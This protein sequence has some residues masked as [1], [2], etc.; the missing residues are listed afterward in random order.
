MK[1]ICK[2]LIIICL[3]TIVCSLSFKIAA[4]AETQSGEIV[5]GFTWEFDNNTLTISGEGALPE[6]LTEYP[7]NSYWKAYEEKIEYIIMDD[8]ITQFQRISNGLATGWGN[9]LDYLS[10]FGDLPALKCISDSPKNGYQWKLNLEE[11]SLTI[12]SDSFKSTFLESFDL[13]KI[14]KLILSDGV[15]CCPQLELNGT[16]LDSVTIGK[17]IQSTSNLTNINTKKFIVDSEN[18]YFSAYEGNLYTKDLTKLVR[19]I[20]FT[21]DF[22]VPAQLHTI[23][24]YAINN[25][26]GNNE[27]IIIPWGV[28]TMEPY[29]LLGV[30][31]KA[32][33]VFPDTVT[34]FSSDVLSV[35][36]ESSATFIY[37]NQNTS[38]QTHLP[39]NS[40][41]QHIVLDSISQYYTI[42]STDTPL[43]SGFITENGKTYY[44][45]D[46]EKMTGLQRINGKAYYLGTDGIMQTSKWVLAD[47][48]WYYLNNYGAGV[49]NCWRLKDG[50]YVYLGA[51]GKMKTN[52]WIKDYNEWYYVKTDGTRYES[53]WAKI[54][55]NWYW[56]GGSG[57]MMSNGWLKLADGKWYYFRSGGQMATGWIKDGNKWYYLTGSGA[58]AAN[59]WV[60]SGSYWYY[61]G[62]SGAMLTNT[63]TPDGYRVDSEG[64]WI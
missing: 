1:Q 20:N 26:L 43:N 10:R 53:S 16:L 23:G 17:D 30:T 5:D 4:H 45:K 47:G 60:K 14:N 58:M 49:V 63:I 50:K 24:N 55:D 40:Y 28:T 42:N 54:D 15:T 46:G 57:K 19:S 62:S 34:I 39:R 33:I 64:R 44:Y 36:P 7:I 21:G 52:C 51:D 48:N 35:A 12:G 59:K 56:F 27:T 41:H 6:S 3:S 61:L 31:W 25:D 8:N 32:T 13:T 9:Q 11:H 38:I 2:I 37:S 29:S 22:K 18:K